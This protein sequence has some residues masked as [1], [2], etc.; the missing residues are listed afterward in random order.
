[1]EKIENQEEIEKITTE[2]SR[3]MGTPVSSKGSIEEM[4]GHICKQE[5]LKITDPMLLDRCKQIID[6]RLRDVRSAQDTQ[7][8]LERAVADGGL[9][10]QGRQLADIMQVIEEGYESFMQKA[11][12]KIVAERAQFV[13]KNQAKFTQ[14]DSRAEQEEKLLTKKYIE[15]TGKMPD[16]HVSP[17]ESSSARVSAGKSVQQSLEDRSKNI[18]TQKVRAVIEATKMGQSVAPKPVSTTRPVMKDIVPQKRLMGPVDELR[19]LSL[20]DFRRMGK[21]VDQA[22]DYILRTVQLL[23]DQG[24]DKRVEAI[25]AWQSSPFYRMYLSLVSLAMQ[26]GT[27]LEDVR[28]KQEDSIE[29]LSKEELAA[30]MQLNKQLRF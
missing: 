14:K 10:V 17:A 5:A 27:S 13:E 25:R 15:M 11:R 16:A 30:V 21:T 24:Y 8:S 29:T 12:E 1:M 2:K 9:G 7:K 20:V 18:D 23:E 3:V 19:Q 26:E 6:S 22:S 4:I 28:A